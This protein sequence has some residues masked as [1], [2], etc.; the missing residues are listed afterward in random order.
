MPGWRTI[1]EAHR[2][3]DTIFV[4][5]ALTVS[6]NNVI[7]RGFGKTRPVADNS[8]AAGRKLNRRVEMIVSGDVIGTQVTPG[9]T[10]PPAPPPQ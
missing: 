2:R 3:S 1:S 6:I 8:T 7:A 5:P 4:M 9:A 10:T